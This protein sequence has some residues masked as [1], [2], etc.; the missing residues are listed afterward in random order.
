MSQL[1]DNFFREKQTDFEACQFYSTPS[2]KHRQKLTEDFEDYVFKA[3]FYGYVKKTILYSSVQIRNKSSQ[4]KAREELSLNVVDPD[5]TE[6]RINLLMDSTGDFTDDIGKLTYNHFT[7]NEISHDQE[8]I[9]AIHALTDR[10]RE[11]LTK[12]ILLGE[13]DT[14]VAAKLGI[15]KQGVNKI[16]NAALNKLKK[17]LGHRYRR[18]I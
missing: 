5:F 4:L 7:Y 10:Q 18:A 11:V 9:K 1:V 14:F 12:C 8:I 17:Q 16:K 15:T 13:S 3:Y 2:E 6:E